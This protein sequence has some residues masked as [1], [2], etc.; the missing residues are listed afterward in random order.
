[1]GDGSLTQDEIDALLQGADDFS[2]ATSADSADGAKAEDEKISPS[3]KDILAEIMQQAFARSSGSIS[4]FVNKDVRFAN[5][6][7]DVKSPQSIQNEFKGKYISFQS[8]LSGAVAGDSHILMPV[9][10]AVKIAQNLLSQDEAKSEELDGAQEQALKEM[11]SPMITAYFVNISHRSNL[12]FSSGI[13]SIIQIK[14]KEDLNIPMVDDYAKISFSMSISGL[15]DTKL[16][17]IFPA[18]IAQKIAQSAMQGAQDA[19]AGAAAQADLPAAGAGQVAIEDVEF[20]DLQSGGIVSTQANLNLLLD[21]KMDLTVELGRT[22]KYVKE[23]LSLGEGSIIELDKLAGE[24]VDLLVNNKL[25]A[26]GEVVVIDENFG[27]RVTDIVKPE[28]RL[29]SMKDN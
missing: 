28:E 23:I 20:P 3:E 14:K 26:R 5:A 15:V 6:Y 27:V 12:N 21:I 18:Q 1:M 10:D 11:M 29:K 2:A 17:Q 9:A 19:G 8:K 16:I 13:I 7:T 25:I 22:R 4:S 24:P